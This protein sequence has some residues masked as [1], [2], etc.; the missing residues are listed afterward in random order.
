MKKSKSS[1]AAVVGANRKSRWRRMQVSA[2]R[3]FPFYLM[4][5][6]GLAFLVV[7]CY[8]PL[9]GILIAFKDYDYRQGILGSPWV[10][11]LFK[12]FEFFFKSDTALTVTFN[13]IFYNLIQL[14]LMTVCAITLAVLL[15][16]IKSKVST[17]VYKGAI[18]LPTFL[19]WIVVQYIVFAILSPDRGLLNNVLG[20]KVNWYME[21]D[22][23][24]V[25]MPLGYLW[26]G[27]GYQSILYVAA[28]SGINTDYYEAAVLD[29]ATRWQKIRYITLPLLRG[30]AMV[31][32]LLNVGKLFNGGLGDWQGF[33]SLPNNSG[34][35]YSTTDVIDT[36]VYRA[37]KNVSNYGMASAAALYQSVVGF[38]LIL[39]TNTIT[40][41][42]D[43]DN[44][45]F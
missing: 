14:V 8:V 33:Y 43:P 28:I 40:K 20:L 24:R 31:L 45:L 34:M 21:P 44:A 19:S 22:V 7:F 32:I 10:D 35:V 15:N 5:L 41:K 3:Q 36:Y 2:R 18:L 29:G 16:E 13:T 9:P 42:K 17:A 6:P 1:T 37:L 11:P 25:I 30:T 38:V 27:L 23:W 4:M 26:K 39:I 12:N